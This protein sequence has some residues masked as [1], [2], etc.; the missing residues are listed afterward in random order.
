V[1]GTIIGLIGCGN[2]GSLVAKAV[3]EGKIRAS[4]GALFDS[5][6][7]RSKLLA[8]RLGDPSLAK[9]SFDE[10]MKSEVQLVVEAASV[11]AVKQYSERVLRS[12]K[13]LMVLSVGALLDDGLRARLVSLASEHGCKIIVP[14]GAIGGLDVLKAGSLG[15]IES[16]TLTTAKN[17][18]SLGMEETSERRLV[19]EGSVERAVELYPRN[20]NVA[21]ALA[22]ASGVR[23][24]VRIFVDPKIRTNVHEVEV[25]G[26]FGEAKFFISNLPSPD[27]PRTSYLAALSVMRA[28]QGIEESIVIGT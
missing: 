23:P 5:K 8:H 17:P 14:S 24:H 22:I 12:G 4:I 6:V 13:D 28:I 9:E 11:D 27:N 15:G 25:K 18:A 19:F 1:R 2:V 3:R 7:D 20:I 21:A 26:A 16:I 10:F